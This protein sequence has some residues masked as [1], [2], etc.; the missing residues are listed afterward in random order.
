[1]TKA[2]K[3]ELETIREKVRPYRYP[4]PM[5]RQRVVARAE[6]SGPCKTY[7]REEIEQYEA[8]HGYR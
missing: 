8:H 7:T 3:E 2:W 1:M 4:L 5:K 6:R